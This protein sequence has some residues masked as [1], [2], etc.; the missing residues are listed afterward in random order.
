MIFQLYE[1]IFQFYT[2]KKKGKKPKYNLDLPIA[3]RKG[4]KTEYG[5]NLPGRN[6]L[7]FR[8]LK[9]PTFISIYL[10]SPYLIILSFH[11]IHHS[12][13][14]MHSKS[15]FSLL[16]TQI[17]RSPVSIHWLATSSSVLKQKMTA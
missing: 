12:L 4:T 11:N 8:E 17:R 6:S 1:I 7:N 2:V 16:K 10:Y 3:I 9:S 15:P 14:S 13:S 5:Q